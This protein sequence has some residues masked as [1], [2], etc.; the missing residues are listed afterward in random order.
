[1]MYYERFQRMIH[2]LPKHPCPRFFQCTCSHECTS[3]DKLIFCSEHKLSC[4]SPADYK[5]RTW[6]ISGGLCNEKVS[7]HCT[8]Q[9]ISNRRCRDSSPRIKNC[10]RCNRS[11]WRWP[12]QMLPRKSKHS[13]SSISFSNTWESS[14]LQG[15]QECRSKGQTQRDLGPSEVT[16]AGCLTGDHQGCA[17]APRR[18]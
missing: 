2:V 17:T 13:S 18:P 9:A 4:Q 1:M 3:K 7:L 14:K 5:D 10:K 6:V 12:L 16:G 11:C 15:P 8:A